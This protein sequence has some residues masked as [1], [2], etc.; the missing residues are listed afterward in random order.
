MVALGGGGLFL[1]SEA[2]LYTSKQGLYQDAWKIVAV[3]R[4]ISYV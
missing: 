1:M 3:E 2:T 4:V